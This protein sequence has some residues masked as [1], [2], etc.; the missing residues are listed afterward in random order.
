MISLSLTGSLSRI[1][2]LFTLSLA[3]RAP[4]KEET[5]KKAISEN[6]L[7]YTR[8]LCHMQEVVAEIE[9]IDKGGNFIGNLILANGKVVYL[10]NKYI[11]IT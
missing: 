9:S 7:H 10:G 11:L 4:R 5:S 3:I 2:L 1:V 6:G 8:S